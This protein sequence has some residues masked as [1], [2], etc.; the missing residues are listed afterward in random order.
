M[1]R[2]AAAAL[3]A[4]TMTLAAGCALPREITKTPRS[5]I[6][7]LLLT[8]AM[9][10][11]L[12]GLTLPLDAIEPLYIEVTGLQPGYLS[13]PIPLSPNSAAAQA[14]GQSPGLSGFFTPSRD[15]D[16][17]RYSVGR[18]LGRQGYRVVS[19]EEQ[20]T[21]LVRVH[22]QSFGTNQSSSFFGLPP[23]TSVVIPFSLPQLTLYQNLAQDGYVRFSLDLIEPT[24]GRRT[25]SSP[26]FSQRTFHDQYTLLFFV[27]FRRTDLDDPP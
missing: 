15:L 25:Y 8:Q 14:L 3:V 7:Q 24:S 26:W 27:T 11:S 9:E 6:E 17:V 4:A 10:R 16:F 23:I 19:R 13:A 21:Y 1:L 18:H 5:A 20:A 12:A 2:Q 22:V